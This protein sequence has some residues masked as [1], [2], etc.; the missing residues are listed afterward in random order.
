MSL[1]GDS[2]WERTKPRNI[3]YKVGVKFGDIISNK[4]SDIRTRVR[5][6]VFTHEDTDVG[7]DG[8]KVS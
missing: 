1:E 8:G 5:Q 6:A 3:S 7:G 4:V 2:L